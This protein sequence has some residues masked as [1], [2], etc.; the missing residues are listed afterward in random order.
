VKSS[1][2][3]TVQNIAFLSTEPHFPTSTRTLENVYRNKVSIHDM[4]EYNN[5]SNFC[6][7]GMEINAFIGSK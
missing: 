5:L 3:S 4:F 6:V 1:A 2:Q 7:G